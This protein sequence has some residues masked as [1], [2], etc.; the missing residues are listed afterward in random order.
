MAPA[1]R[2]LVVVHEKCVR[3]A[4][5]PGWDAWNDDVHLPALCGPGG[6]WAGTRFALTVRPEPG[7]PGLGFTHVTIIELDDPDV[8]AQAQRVLE[9]DEV[10]RADGRMHPAHAAVAADVFVG[11][12]QHGT[13]PAPSVARTGHILAHVLCTDPARV[14]EWDAWYDAV[15]VP[16]M[17]SCGAFSS[18]SR[19]RRLDPVAVGTGDLT[20]YD[21]SVPTIEEAVTR[22]A[23]TLA[24]VITDGRKHE[25]HT[26]ALTLTVRPTGRHGGEGIRRIG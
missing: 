9:V 18:M 8:R 4:D 25:C 10:L 15:H 2:G 16:D 17:L 7:R 24:E 3:A 5:E 26:G 6:A 11:H 14:A 21:V 19:W 13:K 12:G 20:L 23:A 22:S 1:T